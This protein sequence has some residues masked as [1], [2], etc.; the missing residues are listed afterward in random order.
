MLIRP[1]YS[2]PEYRGVLY[3]STDAGR[4]WQ[5]ARNAEPNITALTA[6][7]DGQLWLGDTQGH[8]YSLDPRLLDWS[9]V[10]NLQPTPTPTSQQPTQ[11]APTVTPRPAPPANLYA[12][13]GALA[14]LW[15][16]PQVFEAIG[17]ATEQQP[18]EM[19]AAF[20][21]FEKG[22]MIW[23]GDTN[24][25]YVLY[26]DGSWEQFADT[27]QSDQPESDPHIVPPA[28]RLQPKR[29]FGL[30]WREHE[31]VLEGLGWALEEESTHLVLA[32]AFERGA[33]LKLDGQHYVLTQAGQW[34][35]P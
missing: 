32:Q 9:P 28:G 8:A 5:E 33:L 22:A 26:N 34:W 31:Q 10:A 21:P 7:A 27:W 23:R 17:W 14:E 11:I 29:G 4:T 25:V 13:A 20:Q 1:Y 3:R 16:E 19:D 12:P 18:H 24:Q 15:D 30:V 6:S 2:E 35:H